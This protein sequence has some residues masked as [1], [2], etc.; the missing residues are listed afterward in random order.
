MY[1]IKVDCKNPLKNSSLVLSTIHGKSP[2]WFSGSRNIVRYKGCGPIAIMNNGVVVSGCSTTC[3]EDVVTNLDTCFGNGCCRTT[4]PDYLRSFTFNI[5]ELEGQDG[6][7]S[8]FLVDAYYER[9]FPS[10]LVVGDHTFV[11]ISLSWNESFSTSQDEDEDE[12]EDEDETCG[13]VR[14]PYPFGINKNSSGAEFF[15]VDCNSSTQYLPALNNVEVLAVNASQ[16]MVTV[17]VL[18]ISECENTFQN[19]SLVL[20]RTRLYFSGFYNI[21][22]FEGCGS[23]ALMEEN[24]DIAGVRLFVA[25]TQLRTHAI[26]LAL[27]VIANLPFLI[28][29]FTRNS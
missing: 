23:V 17:N 18:R 3:G 13:D 29:I 27:E 4:I 25:T 24:E 9:R 8:V 11:P 20:S 1:V 10:Q 26:G 2:F 6:C 14:I 16:Q 15:N 7:G 28:F 5:A 22:V 21:F 12:Y 19:N